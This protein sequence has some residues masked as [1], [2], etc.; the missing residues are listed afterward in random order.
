MRKKETV[1]YEL[2]PNR[3]SPLTRAQRAELKTL[4]MLPEAQIDTS[5][6][7]LL[8]ETFWEN[9]V[10]NPLYRPVKQQLTVR[11]DA[12]ILT[13]LRLSGRGYQTKLNTVLRQAMV[14]DV[15][16]QT[17]PDGGTGGKRAEVKQFGP[18]KAKQYP[19][20]GPTAVAPTVSNDAC[21]AWSNAFSP[22]F[23]GDRL[24]D[25]PRT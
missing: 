17:R 25:T 11:L 4:A 6:I 9:A 19:R 21:S 13:W 8:S 24:H 20:S 5:E 22:P 3:L 15:T 1:S 12:D 18:P 10:R 2:D 23:T 16:A 7:A 14:R